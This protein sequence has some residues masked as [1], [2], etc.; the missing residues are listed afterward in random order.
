MARWD[1][2]QAQWAAQAA[3]LCAVTGKDE[4]DLTL[5]RGKYVCVVVGGGRLC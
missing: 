3:A 1:A 2:Q 5:S 4:K